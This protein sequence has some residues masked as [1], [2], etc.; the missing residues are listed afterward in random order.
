MKKLQYVGSIGV[1]M[2]AL[3]SVP[4][5]QADWKVAQFIDGEAVSSVIASYVTTVIAPSHRVFPPLFVIGLGIVL[6]ALGTIALASTEQRSRRPY[7]FPSPLLDF[8][9]RGKHVRRSVPKKKSKLRA[10]SA[11]TS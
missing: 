2:A 5:A 8:Q 3:L 6:V 11:L 4:V 9:N 7:R 10:R 1:F